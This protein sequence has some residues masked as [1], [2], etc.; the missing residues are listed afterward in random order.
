MSKD[1]VKNLEAM[2]DA[3]RR[4]KVSAVII[5]GTDPHQSEYVN[6]HWKVRDW[7]TG[8]TGSNGTA[9]VTLNSA[10]LW[11][12]SRYFLQAADQLQDSGFD[13]H[14]ED[15]PGEATITEWLAEEMNDDEILAVDGRL[16]SLNKANQLEEFC[17]ANGLRF[18]TDFA[19][20]DT[21]W[22]NRPARPMSKAFVHDI[23]YAGESA[24]SKIERVLEQVENM[25]ADAI[26]MPAL[27]EIAWT[28]NIRGADVEC[29]PLVVSYLYLS[30]DDKVLFVDAE[31]ID[32]E[33][34][35]YLDGIGVS[36][37]AYDEVQDY[38]KK[39]VKPST[40]VLLDPNQVSDTLGRALEC[41]KVYAKSPVAPLKAI[42]NEVQIAGTRNAMERDGAALVRLWK[43][44]EENAGTGKITEVDVANKAIEC[45][46]VSE[47][48]RGESFGMIA[49][50]KEHGA[51]VHYSAKPETASALKAE[52]LLLVDTG[53]QYLDGTTDI[54]RTMSLGN[55]TE[56]ERH[57]YTLVLKGHLALGRAKFPVG[58]RGSQLDALA[59]I[60]QWNEMMTYLHGTGHGVGHFLGVHEGPQNI[61]LNE[62][63]TTLKPGMITSNEPGLYKAGQYGIR[64]ENLVL[65]VP[66]GHS[67]E[68]GDFL[69][70]ETLTLF[71]YDTNLIDLSMLSREEIEQVNAYHDEVRNRLTPY[72]NEEE[73]AWLNKRTAKI[74]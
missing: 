61:R 48:Y 46:S 32:A 16:F 44:I 9:V 67:E 17:G 58:T 52:G 49:G 4:V 25:G 27:D 54:T 68:F 24:E 51:I 43:W 5:P 59:R 13:L 64:T 14:K 11:T 8:F 74:Q 73:Q 19:P 26:F 18:A 40:A 66:A 55:P 72:L 42:K 10:G 21:I 45:R 31:K 65:T 36:V 29:N 3:M 56:S 2:R 70:F 35:A 39:K 50:Y 12:D 20:A 60:Y 28:L 15:I 7:I 30:Q 22:E 63:P 41:Y 38:L 53:A 37:V 33:V 1:T 71:P 62:N 34:A 47:L 6:P 69:K 57:D 23:K